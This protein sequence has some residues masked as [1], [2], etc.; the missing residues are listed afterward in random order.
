MWQVLSINIFNKYIRAYIIKQP[1]RKL[2]LGFEMSFKNVCTLDSF[3]ITDQL[4]TVCGWYNTAIK[5]CW[6]LTE[7]KTNLEICPY[8]E[9]VSNSKF[10]NWRQICSDH[11]NQTSVQTVKLPAA[12]Y[13][14]DFFANYCNRWQQLNRKSKNHVITPPSVKFFRRL[15]RLRD[16]FTQCS[17]TG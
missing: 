1:S 6:N 10:A 14:Q 15:L 2:D 9:K 12:N 3:R 5:I 7:T 17:T 8:A 4:A 16:F 13:F 11:V